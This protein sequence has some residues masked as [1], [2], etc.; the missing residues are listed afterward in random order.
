MFV[1]FSD[2]DGTLIDH[3]TYSVEAA[4]GAAASLKHRGAPLVLCSSKTRAEI[5]RLQRDL[6]SVHP[7]VCENGGGVFVPDGYFPFAIP[8]ARHL[9][10]WDVIDLGRPYPDVVEA[11]RAAAESSG[12]DLVGFHDMTV[13][14]V[15]RDS[16]LDAATA[17]LAKE[18]DYDEAFRLASPEAGASDLARLVQA[19]TSAGL[20]H[21]AGGRYHHASGPADKGYAVKLLARFFRQ[22]HGAVTTVGLGDGPNDVPMLLAVDIPIVVSNRASGATADVVR[23]VPGARATRRD[24][25]EGWRDAIEDLLR[26]RDGQPLPTSP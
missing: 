23:Q 12:V 1:V 10:A 3:S 26:E 21:S 9:G 6:Q 5:A 4:R 20:C 17:R 8:A 24:G 2:I 11:L 13:E 7:F 22:A 15:A 19:M 14:E 18:R 25:P 16:G